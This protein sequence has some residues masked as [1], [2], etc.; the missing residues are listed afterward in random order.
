MRTKFTSGD[1]VTTHDGVEYTT[2]GFA[3]TGA[4]VTHY[5]NQGPGGPTS[6]TYQDTE[7][8]LFAVPS[9]LVGAKILEIAEKYTNTQIAAKIAAAAV[10][11]D[12]VLT[13]S[14]VAHRVRRALAAKAREKGV[15]VTTVSKAFKASRKLNGVPTRAPRVSRAAATGRSTATGPTGGDDDETASQAAA[16]EEDFGVK[17]AGSV[18]SE[19]TELESEAEA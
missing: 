19:M 18:V 6:T 10:G 14:G 11:N 7:Q 16:Y 12:A 17:R 3:E 8:H 4:R 9:L 2:K 1:P 13:E 5:T 15:S